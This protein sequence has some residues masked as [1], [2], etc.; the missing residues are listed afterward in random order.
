M[1][2]AFSTGAK[3]AE[4]KERCRQAALIDGFYTTELMTELRRIRAMVRE[5]KHGVR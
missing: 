2:G 4:G 3:T 1:H 5:I